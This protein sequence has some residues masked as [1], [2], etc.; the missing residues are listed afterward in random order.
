M[1]RLL[2]ARSA[3]AIALGVIALVIAASGGALAA[4]GGGS[5]TAC[6]HKNSGGLYRAS[7]CAKHDRKLTWSV[8]GPRGGV[9]PAGP[10]GPEAPR[11]DVGATGPKGETGATGETG[12][13]GVPG[14]ARGFA[15]VD[16][17]GTVVTEGG[18]I[19]IGIHKIKTGAYCLKLNPKPASQTFVP[20]V[21]TIQGPDFTAG[22]IN[23]NTSFGSD[24]NVDGGAG[25]FTM[26]ASGVPTDHQFVVA[27]M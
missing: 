23:V 12:P 22:L 6:V 11:G 13:Q 18:A 1:S 20:I 27:V 8:A 4:S 9:G 7:R 24:C 16:D 19:H 15:F 26:N 10:Q 21:A 3:P 25:V 14:S 5:I 2:S 17:D